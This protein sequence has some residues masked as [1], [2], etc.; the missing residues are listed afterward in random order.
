MQLRDV[1]KKLWSVWA[2][3]LTAWSWT[4]GAATR[5]VSLGLN[6]NWNHHLARSANVGWVRVDF[7]WSNTQPQRGVWDWTETDVHV[8]E[9]EAN[10]LKM[11]AILHYV[12]SWAN[13]GGSQSTPP[14]TTVDWAEWV[15]QLAIRYS[16]RIAAYEIWNEPDTSGNGGGIG[17]N[18]NV[19]E[20]PLYTDFVHAAAQQIRAYS[21]GSLVVGPSY[22][23]RNDGANSQADNRKRRFMQQMNATWYPDGHGPTFLDVM[24][25]HNN[26]GDTE[27]SRTMGYVLRW[28]N[29]SYLDHVP[30]KKTAPIWVTEYG[31]RSNAVTNNGQ[32]EKICNVTKIYTGALEAAY[33][34]LGN[35]NV[36]GAFIYVQNDGTSA[37]IFN[38]DNTP[39]PVVTQYLQRLA[40]PAVQQP[41]TSAG[42]PNCTG[43]LAL[44]DPAFALADAR[45][46]WSEH[47]LRDPLQGLPADYVALYGERSDDG[48]AA[49]IV[50][51]GANGG[52]VSVSTRPAEAG[53]VQFVSDSA[54]EWNRGDTHVTITPVGGP[55]PGK[56]W[57]R[58][59]A[60][61]VDAGFPETC[62]EDRRLV[63][64]AAVREL[65]FRTPKAP[66]GFV[67][68]ENRLDLTRLS[69]GCAS[70]QAG[71]A[72][73]FDFTWSF[74]GAGG[75]IVRSGIYRYE[76][77]FNG[78][79][80]NPSSLHWSDGRG[81][82]YWVAVEAK[83]L[84]PALE[85]T[86][87]AVAR[88]LDPSFAREPRG[89][90]ARVR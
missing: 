35:Y 7:V 14:T 15:R 89:R 27:A 5:P 31:W 58:K 32:R 46:Q 20:P 55:E 45:V 37:S 6:A 73:N 50:Y 42:Y 61:S 29:L 80:I 68:H 87:Y 77:G 39:K 78:E 9:A 62:V 82:R 16:G 75:E 84:T 21:P 60:T 28:Q 59:L 2:I 67:A 64:D 47:G 40:Y 25:F 81:T 12:P 41:T 57:A 63:D 23:S 66:R 56:G 22:K 18:R 38:G 51:K 1:A 72:K 17:W 24:S 52:I 86:L 76:D 36:N 71:A 69:G 19:E 53:D 65:G 13:G 85:D 70:A 79:T 34:G 8:N 3:A 10:G 74:I 90:E 54:A 43:A 83:E 33:T 4:A 88:S 30:S 48:R 11:L 26:A 44:Q 49:S